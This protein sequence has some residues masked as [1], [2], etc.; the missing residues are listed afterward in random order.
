MNTVRLGIIGVGNMGFAHAK[1]ITEGN[2]PRVTLSCIADTDPSR[3]AFVKERLPD[4]VK[5]YADAQ[6]LLNAHDCDA[7]LI[8]TPHGFHPPIAIDAFAQGYHVMCEKPAGITACAVRE[9]N[10]AAERSG[11]IFGIMF[12]QR[13]NPRYR[14]IRTLIASGKLGT[15][16]RSVWII[17]DW[18]RTQAYYDS[19]SWRATWAG[20]GGGILLNQCPHQLDLMQWICG[21]PEQVDAEMDF[22]RYHKIE[23][24]D[25]VSVRMRYPNG[26]SGVFIASTGDPL[27]VNRL[28]ITLS[29]GKI[30]CENGTLRAWMLE[31]D[32]TEYI[33]TQEIPYLAQEPHEI[34][35]DLPD[36]NT[37]HCG[38]LNNFADA[39]LSG[40][41]LIAPGYEGIKSLCLSNA[42][43]LSAWTNRPITLPSDPDTEPA[44]WEEDFLA[45]LQA[46]A[47]RSE[48]KQKSTVYAEPGDLKKRYRL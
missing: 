28:E 41:P 15:L 33:R 7:V 11:K 3:L 45:Q 26:A 40:A 18:Y 44:F 22:G 20:E 43:H 42:M 48:T 30:L 36:E 14:A 5:C 38:I 31:K 25:E 23:V 21:L 1:A 46:R 35:L 24:E 34:T 39:I 8:A 16:R 29:K 6:S 10:R 47:A 2:C 9:M 12:N 4:E 13:T 27:G 37:Q 17:T 32:E 19:G